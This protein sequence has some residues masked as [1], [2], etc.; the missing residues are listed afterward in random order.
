MKVLNNILD[1]SDVSKGER[2]HIIQEFTIEDDD[3]P[4]HIDITI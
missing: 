2:K 1:A 3:N 4:T